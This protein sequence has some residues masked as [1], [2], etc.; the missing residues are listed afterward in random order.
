MRRVRRS[1]VQGAHRIVVSAVPE[2]SVND[3]GGKTGAMYFLEHDQSRWC[4]AMRWQM[5]FKSYK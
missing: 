4:F 3:I 5:H 2:G 1:H